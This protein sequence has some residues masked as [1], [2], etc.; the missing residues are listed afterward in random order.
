MN[1]GSEESIVK[2]KG[3]KKRV[4]KREYSGVELA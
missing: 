3:L 4:K 1:S 2:G